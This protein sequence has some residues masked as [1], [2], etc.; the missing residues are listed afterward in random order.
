MGDLLANHTTLRLGGPADRLV[1]HTDPA[2]WTDLVLGLHTPPFILGGGSNTLADDAGHPGTAVRM[3]TRGT[4]FRRHGNNIV[5]VT[6][7]AGEP[8]AGLVAHCGAVRHRVPW[9][10]SRHH[11]RRPGAEHRRLRPADLRRPRPPHGLRLAAAH[12][13]RT[14][15]RS[16]CIRLPHQHLQN[17]ARPLDH[18]PARAAHDPRS[19]RGTGHQPPPR[20]RPRHPPRR[21]PA[22]GG[23]RRRRSRRPLPTRPDPARHRT[24]RTT[25]GLGLPQPAPHPRPG[26]PRPDSRRTDLPRRL[27]HP[28]HQRRLASPADRP[29]PGQSNNFRRTLLNPPYLD[30]DR[31]PRGDLSRVHHSIANTRS[32][33]PGIHYHP[34]AP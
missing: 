17:Q 10:H 30:P 15:T 13:H 26:P 33:G 21:A 3:A 2:H 19:E 24:G 16:L 29:L 34:P 7:Q 9:R 31:P 18:P 8:L 12:D 14:P 23:S 4:T 20:R 22:P 32:P 1:T 25:G 5:E 11:R 27:R 6:V 28:S